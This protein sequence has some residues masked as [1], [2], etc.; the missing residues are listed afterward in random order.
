ML[1]QGKQII[2]VVHSHI[3]LRP[4][5]ADEFK[6]GRNDIH[7]FRHKKVDGK[8]TNEREAIE[9]D[10]EKKYTLLFVDKNRS[11][12]DGDVIVYEF[13]GHYARFKEKGFCNPRV[14]T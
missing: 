8:F 6:G 4:I 7:P 10:P 1:S 2:E 5:K 3:M 13:A 11:G 12:K 14:D 9:L